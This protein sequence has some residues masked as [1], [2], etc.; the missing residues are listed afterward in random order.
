MAGGDRIRTNQLKLLPASIRFQLR[1][2]ADAV[3]QARHAGLLGA[4]LAAEE[5]PLLLQSVADD[6]DAAI[7]AC[8]RQRMNGA[9]EAVEGVSGVTHRH[10]KG[11]V[12]IVSAGFTSGHDDLAPVVLTPTR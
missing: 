12:V 10:L 11:L 9:F 4:M 5:G 6:A 7:L 1:R 8:R 3:A 2:V